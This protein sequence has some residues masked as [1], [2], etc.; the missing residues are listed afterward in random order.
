MEEPTSKI[1]HAAGGLIEN[2]RGE[3]LFLFRRNIWDLPKGKID[4]GEGP[5]ECALREVNEET[6]IREIKL[7]EL[8]LV[9]HHI[10]EENGFSILKE[11]HWFRMKAPGNQAL[12][13]QLEEDITEL[14]W[15][16]EKGFDEVKKNTYPN[17]LDVLKAAGFKLS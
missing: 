1:V 14:R 7:Q 8:L 10:Y 17:I 2:E 4:G 3:V 13:P 9:T 5:E 6:G 11:T 15:I 16:A 12:V